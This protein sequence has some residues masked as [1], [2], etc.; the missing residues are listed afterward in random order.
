[1][2][3]SLS[4]VQKKLTGFVHGLFFGSVFFLKSFWGASAPPFLRLNLPRDGPDETTELACEGRDDDRRFLAAWPAELPVAVVQPALRFPRRVGH[5]LGQPFL[6]FLQMRCEAGRRAVMVRRL[7]QRAPRV[8]VAH[9]G[10]AALLPVGACRMFARAQP[11]VTHQLL[12]PV[13]AV[14]IP[15]LGDQG[16]GVEQTH[17]AQTLVGRKL[18]GSHAN[19]AQTSQTII[20]RAGSDKLPGFTAARVK[21]LDTQRQAW[22]DAQAAQAEAETAAIKARAELKEL[23]KSITDRRF[24]IQLAADAQWSHQEEVNGAVRKEFG[25]STKR[26]LK[27]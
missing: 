14:Q 2:T 11:Q 1:M 18:N 23:V 25:L 15:Q 20:N 16:G 13:E 9:L 12:G 8:A 19:L 22:L 3:G 24:V 17:P 5:A 7:H 27:V 10:D 26:P 6:A 4:L 21:A